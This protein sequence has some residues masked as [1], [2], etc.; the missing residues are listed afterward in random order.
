MKKTRIVATVGPASDSKENMLKIV[1]AGVNVFRLNFSHNTHESHKKIIDNAKEVRK[2][3]KRPL[4]VLADLQ[5]PRIR[6]G[7]AE[8]FEIEKGE[9]I[10]VS[11]QKTTDEKELII[12]SDRVA[13]AL[14][15]GERIMI[16]DGLL[17]L[18]VVE[19]LENSVK[20]EVL[21]GGMVKPRKGINVPDTKL[22]FGAVTK[23]DKNDLEFAVKEDVDFVALSFV[24]NAQEVLETREEI[25]KIL[26]RTDSLPQI[27]VKIERKE[28]IDNIDEI[29][30]ATDVVMVARGDLGIELAE[31]K[32]IIY[33]KE[34]IAKCLRAAKPVIVATQMLD[35]MINN[36]IPTRA[37]VS[38]VSNAV[39]DHTDA[40]MLSGE[41]ANGKYPVEAVETM[42]QIIRDTEDSPFD[43]INMQYDNIIYNDYD[44]VINSAHDL[45]MTSGA[46]AVVL[47][48]DAGTSARMISHHRPEQMILVATCNP[49]TYNQMS[50]VWGARSY[51][52]ECNMHDREDMIEEVIELNKKA[53]RL[54]AGD[55]IVVIL[56]KI[57]GR[58]DVALT[59]IRIVE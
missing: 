57:P 21:N 26:G 6:V 7:N 47:F 53:G 48:S 40:V 3:I 16:E 32:V 36:P 41:S 27:V 38:D 18:K 14:Q 37:E 10:F 29:I 56:G 58:K 20:A 11:D 42:A 50:I 28:A 59:G 17:R 55:K 43:D 52:F 34:I 23:K 44:S 31:S 13:S 25:K 45:A 35:S 33:Q 15:V 19:R 5:G 24:S 49:K 46:K 22:H 39:I 2:E 8:A 12:D 30:A 1:E 4:G 9:M 51:L 54:Q